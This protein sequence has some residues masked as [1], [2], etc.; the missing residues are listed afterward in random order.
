MSVAERPPR[1]LIL[2]ASTGNGHISAALALEEVLKAQGAEARHIDTLDFAPK[3][4]RLWYAGGY[5]ALVR[6]APKL[7]GFLYRD[8]DRISASFRVQTALDIRFLTRIDRF[9]AEW[10]PDGVLC[11]H[12]LPQPRLA[13]LRQRGAHFKMGIVI[14]D[15]HPQWMW[16]RGEP[17]FFYVPGAWT[18]ERLMERLPSAAGRILETGI[19]VNS[20]FAQPLS[21]K[22]ARLSCALQPDL[23]TL[24]VSAGG[25]GAGP[26]EETLDAIQA[27]PVAIQIVVV[28]GRNA[29]LKERLS[30]SLQTLQAGS[31]HT[32][33]LKGLQ[34]QDEMARLTLASDLLIGKP[35]GLTTSESLIAGC[36]M[37]IYAPFMIPG[38]EERNAQMLVE[39]GAGVLASNVT[40]L[41]VALSRLLAN[42]QERETMRHNALQ[43][44]RPNSAQDIARHFLALCALTQK[45]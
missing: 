33:H 3:G 40:E 1:I 35:G 19:P 14:T 17:D 38:Q 5:E 28:C 11:T 45:I 13:L 16:L 41:R 27:L 7:W 25:I 24:L 15:L 29:A 10:K 39:S 21:R 37:L 8:S 44:A 43:I 9:I 26:F 12:S 6:Y 30:A 36:P 34:T 31:P 2:S 20:A 22:E 32:F 18:R 42:P 23:P 4:F